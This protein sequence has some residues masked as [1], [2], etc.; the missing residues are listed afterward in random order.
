ISIGTIGIATA[1]QDGWAA[2]VMMKKADMALYSAKA[3]GGGTYRMFEP[4]MEAWAHRRRALETG[5]RSAIDNGELFVVFQPLM[6][7][8]KG[9][10]AGCE[11]LVR[12]KSAEW[13]FVPPTEFIP[14]AESTGLIEPIGEWVLREALRVARQWPE[15]TTVAVNLSAVQFKSQKL[16]SSVVSALADAGMPAHRLELEVTESIFVD[17]NSAT[18]GMLQNLRALGV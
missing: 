17:G 10:I 18:T 15:D 5:L 2:D 9:T 7:L 1:P 13:G 3:D 8:R 11:A 14:V 16:L 6:D 12:W 4:E